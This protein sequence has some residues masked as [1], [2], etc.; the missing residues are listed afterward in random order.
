[1]Q[2]GHPLVGTG[3]FEQASLSCVLRMYG[4]ETL[5]LLLPQIVAVD[6]ASV[7]VVDGTVV[8][9]AATRIGPAPCTGCGRCTEWVHSAY[10]RHVADEAVGGRPAR[11]DLTVRR[12]YCENPDCPNVTF[13]EQ[14]PGLTVITSTYL[15][16]QRQESIPTTS[17]LKFRADRPTRA[18]RHAPCE[19]S[20]PRLIGG[21]RR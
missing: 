15:S 14:F 3:A 6:V 20:R 13:A 2:I 18:L 8:I 17:N 1:L 5:L 11:I 10:G 16:K 19:S 4:L 12:L 21:P 7:A 9:A